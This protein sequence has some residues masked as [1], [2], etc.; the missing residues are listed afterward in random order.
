M[1]EPYEI[2]EEADEQR[3]KSNP[4][5]GYVMMKSVIYRWVVVWADLNCNP[6]PF[7]VFVRPADS[8]EASLWLVQTEQSEIRGSL[9]EL[10]I[11]K[12]SA[13]FCLI[14]VGWKSVQ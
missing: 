8:R 2:R 11:E 10:R 4:V 7:F 1:H 14:K 3:E 5:R 6:N 13:D 12:K 9:K